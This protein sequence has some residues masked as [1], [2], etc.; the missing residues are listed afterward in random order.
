M[1]E[2][3][4]RVVCGCGQ[5]CWASTWP[6][7]GPCGGEMHVTEDYPGVFIHWCDR[8]GHPEEP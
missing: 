1:A 8:H 5:T 6:E 7:E 3:E 2:E 4:P